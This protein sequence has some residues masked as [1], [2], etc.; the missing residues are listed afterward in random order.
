MN[1]SPSRVEKNNDHSSHPFSPY[2]SSAEHSSWS[3]GWAR[4]QISAGPSRT[5]EGGGGRNTFPCIV[6][7]ARSSRRISASLRRALMNT[8]HPD[9]P[10]LVTSQHRRRTNEVHVVRHAQWDPRN[11]GVWGA[12]ES[13]MDRRTSGDEQLM[14]HPPHH[15]RRH[16]QTRTPSKAAPGVRHPVRQA[17]ES[18][19]SSNS[20]GKG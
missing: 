4:S 6:P 15:I 2:R 10:P 18:L 1:T 14:P 9:T 17:E 3:Q 5:G 20:R 19:S 16:H 11:L 13:A 7:Q 12:A 8:L